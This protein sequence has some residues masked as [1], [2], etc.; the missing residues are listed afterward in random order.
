MLDRVGRTSDD[1]FHCLSGLIGNTPMLRINARCEGRDITVY[2]KAEMYNFSGSIKARM[3]LNIIRNATSSGA[4]KPGQ[5]IAEATSGNAG[6]AMAALG[7]AL[8]HPVTIFMPD[9][10]SVER[11]AIIAS[12]GADIRL[13]SKEEGGFL[14]SIAMAEALGKDEGAFLPRQFS[15]DDNCNAHCQGTA[16][17]IWSQVAS[18]GGQIGGF[19]AGVGTG[20]TV[21]GVGRFLKERDPSISVHPVEP[22]ESPTLSTGHKVGHH[23]IQ[24][25]S[26]EF[27]PEIVK[28]DQVDSVI[29]VNDGDS[30]LMAQKLCR[31]M[32]LGVGISSG[33]N[34][35]AAIRCALQQEPDA[36]GKYRAVATVF[37]DSNSKYLSTDLAK[38]EPC[39]DC[40][41][42]P[43]IELLDMQTIR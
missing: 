30:I 4:L 41:L 16:P 10:M 42:T 20:G 21:M 2:A 29:A 15:N 17:E 22:V 40:Y 7:T 35:I 1:K 18:D 39:R 28:L 34:L 31:Q 8:G 37:P 11:R 38:E 33:G 5:R 9:W 14:G 13:V 36:D 3:A 6:I 26:D 23:R 19:V 25:V 32:G 43:K 24:G 12:H 27:I